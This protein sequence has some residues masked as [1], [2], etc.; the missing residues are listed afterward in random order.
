MVFGVFGCVLLAA[1][2]SG[3]WIAP[4]LWWQQ[5]LLTVAG[6]LA[7]TPG[8]VTDVIGLALAAITL[9]LPRI[10]RGQWLGPRAAL[11]ASGPSD[12]RKKG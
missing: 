3:H 11:E 2:M 9:A 1:A 10:V 12:G 5:V 6:I 8:L 4:L 7:M